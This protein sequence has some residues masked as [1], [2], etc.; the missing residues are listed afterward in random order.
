MKDEL[1]S[2]VISEFIGLKSKI[3][4]LISVDDEEKIRAKDVNRKLKYSEFVD[5][6]SN[7]KV[8]RRNMKRIQSRRHRLGTYDVFKVSLSCFG[9]QR[10]V[11]D[12]GIDSLAYF[13]K[14]I[15][16]SYN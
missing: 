14:Y 1:G 12:N 5:V 6:L 9:D 2:K 11:L 13:P 16:S 7:K 4:P 15:C 10:Y 3:Y 8:L